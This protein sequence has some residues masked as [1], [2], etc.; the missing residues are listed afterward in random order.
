VIALDTNVLVRFLVE[1]DAEQTARVRKLLQQAIDSSSS[2]Y[3]SDIV[4][5]EIVWVLERS[6]KLRR[7]EISQALGRVLRARHL[8]FTSF[9]RLVRALEAYDDGRGDFA[10]YLIREHAKTSGCQ[11]VATFDELFRDLTTGLGK[12][13]LATS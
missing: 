5:C 9:E 10:D 4:M 12:G 2:C 8:A 7:A 6:Y 1:D 13:C 11:T 3:V